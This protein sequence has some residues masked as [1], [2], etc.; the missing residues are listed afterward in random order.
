MGCDWFVGEV[1]TAV[2]P[3]CEFGVIIFEVVCA[4]LWAQKFLCSLRERERERERVI[5]WGFLLGG[6][7]MCVSEIP[8]GLFI[9]LFVTKL[10]YNEQIH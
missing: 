2:S 5:A 9:P 4:A 1:I 8:H 7:L 3:L 10:S 6:W